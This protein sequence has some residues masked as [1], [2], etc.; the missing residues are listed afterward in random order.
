MFFPELDLL[1]DWN[2]GQIDSEAP[3]SSYMADGS[4]I[5]CMI[6]PAEFIFLRVSQE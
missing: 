6:G 2:D 1:D 3:A 5:R 4:Q